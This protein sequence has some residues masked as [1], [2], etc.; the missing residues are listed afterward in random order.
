MMSL[1][2]AAHKKVMDSFVAA[3]SMSSCPLALGLWYPART[4]LL[5]RSNL[6]P[7]TM[8]YAACLRVVGAEATETNAE[9]ELLAGFGSTDETL[10]ILVAGL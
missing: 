4:L 2:R 5:E 10:T 3:R 8:A 9:G 1:V 6:Q 7:N